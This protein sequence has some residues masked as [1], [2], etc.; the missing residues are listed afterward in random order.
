MTGANDEES[1]SH[2]GEPDDKSDDTL[3]VEISGSLVYK[4]R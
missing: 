2:S 4:M 3:C 1:I